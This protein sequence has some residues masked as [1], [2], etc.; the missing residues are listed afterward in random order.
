VEA[1]SAE[2][3]LNDNRAFV[4]SLWATAREPNIAAS[5]PAA[6]KTAVTAIEALRWSWLKRSTRARKPA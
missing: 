3:R 5:M 6:N 1:I 4:A 2:A